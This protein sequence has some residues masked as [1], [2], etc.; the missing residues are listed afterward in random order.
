MAGA[1]FYTPINSTSLLRSFSNPYTEERSAAA[2]S[3]RSL[4]SFPQ[5]QS[6]DT[7]LADVARRHPAGSADRAVPER[8]GDGLPRRHLD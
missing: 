8:L 2:R 7:A 6:P 3:K 1:N 5:T 4:I